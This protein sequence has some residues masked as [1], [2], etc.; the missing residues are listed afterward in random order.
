MDD[1]TPF[2]LNV[3]S[4]L[5]PISATR[6]AIEIANEFDGNGYYL[7][8]HLIDSVRRCHKV[9]V[10][11][12][13]LD[14]PALARARELEIFLKQFVEMCDAAPHEDRIAV[15]EAQMRSLVQVLEE[16]E[17]ILSCNYLSECMGDLRR[18]IHARYDRLPDL[19]KLDDAITKLAVEV[20]RKGRAPRECTRF[21]VDR[22]QR[23]SDQHAEAFCA[24]IEDL[25]NSPR[26][27]FH[28][29]V[30]FD[31]VETIRHDGLDAE[32]QFYTPRPGH[33]NW[34]ARGHGRV[35]DPSLEEFCNSHWF[36][37]GVPAS[38]GRARR[39]AVVK[40]VEVD[41]WDKDDARV[42]G[43]RAAEVLV[44]L[45]NAGSRTRAIGVKRKVLVRESGTG[46]VTH[47]KG[48]LASIQ[49]AKPLRLGEPGLMARSLRF[50]SRANSERSWTMAILF[51][52]IALENLF[53]AD[54]GA[55]TRVHSVVPEA[56][57]RTALRD[58]VTYPR[59][60]I[61][62]A[63][64]AIPDH[65]SWDTV[66]AR[67]GM[68]EAAEKS[69]PQF[70]D[71][72][73]ALL[74][75]EIYSL[76]RGNENVPSYIEYRIA[77]FGQCIADQQNLIR[78]SGEVSR[79]ARWA[80]Q[81]ALYLRNRTVHEALHQAESER[82]LAAACREVVDAAFEV[83][84][85]WLNRGERDPYAA[86]GAFRQM[87]GEVK[88]HWGNKTVHEILLSDVIYG[89]NHSGTRP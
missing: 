28:V 51:Y 53:S 64:K 31:Q 78:W 54:S 57:W 17:T 45:I 80:L 70:E 77:V 44:D 39:K 66:F 58:T 8:M 22:V 79:N 6:E 34:P 11:D 7:W 21:V 5:S 48:T 1:V 74:S 63:S 13:M 87:F 47:S 27:T 86:M 46:V 3:H 30:V 41:A 26:R 40:I 65:P 25:L 24:A 60:L 52:W 38:A 84:A 76:L 73:K 19:K 49:Y 29:A 9:L 82:S 61:K 69:R 37:D 23:A 33:T 32:L 14:K 56:V 67:L 15:A 18:R 89:G 43:L 59:Q 81:R 12:R 88:E 36:P 68:T 2:S 16:I 10:D 72:L 62:V 71:T 4:R 75:E 50:A 83:C 20:V 55:T 42:R 85:F 35:D